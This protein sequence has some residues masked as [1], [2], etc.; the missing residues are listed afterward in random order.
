MLLFEALLSFFECK[1]T[2]VFA[3]NQVFSHKNT[4]NGLFIDLRQLPRLVQLLRLNF[5][6]GI[7][8]N[9]LTKNFLPS[10]M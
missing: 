4:P 5:P 2:T 1:I 7:A 3:H 8:V 9:Y 6:M 10:M